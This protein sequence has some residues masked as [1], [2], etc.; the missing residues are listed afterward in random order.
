MRSIETLQLDGGCTV[1]DFTNTI[2]NRYVPDPY[3]YL[4]SYPDF[5]AWAGKVGLLGVSRIQE[6]A[7]YA[8]SHP[9]KTA[10]AFDRVVQ[11]RELLFELFSVIADKQTPEQSIVSAYNVILREAFSHITIT[12]TNERVGATFS[13]SGVSL[14]A[15][16]HLL[17][18]EAFDLLMVGRLD[19]IK[20]CSN[21][22]WL[23]LDQ[24]KNG[25]R[26]WCNMQVCGSRDKSKRYYHN[27]KYM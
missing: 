25:K 13:D 20:C 26:R 7:D 6:L 24:T 21:C 3:D 11:H 22:G 1:F 19:R 15:P 17:I 14:D 12:I 2:N 5:L 18:K 23:F 27:K 4:G 8:I 16:L 10:V 9:R